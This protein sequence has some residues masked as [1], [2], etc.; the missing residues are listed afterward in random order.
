MGPWSNGQW[1]QKEGR[2]LGAIE[3]GSNTADYFRQNVE[4]PFFNRYLK[5][6]RAPGLPRALVFQTGANEWR[7]LDAWPPAASDL[8][9][10][11]LRADGRLTWEPPSATDPGFR[12]Y[13]SDPA[14]PVP[15]TSEI[16]QWYNPAFMLQDQRFASTRT[17]VLVYQTDL[18]QSDVTVAGPVTA[19]LSVSTSGTDSDWVVKVI[20][21][22]PDTLPD[23]AALACKTPLGGYQMLVRGDVMRGKFRNSL[24]VPEPFVPDRVA[25]VEFELQDLFHTFKQGHRIMVQVQSTWF[26]MIDLNPQKFTDIFRAQPGDFRKALQRVYSTPEAG[27]LLR[28]PVLK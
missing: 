19:S 4:L 14:K 10:L 11:H 6:Q 24:A 9:S 7:S 12:E 28:M 8:R 23:S 15:Y 22:F 20:D 3:F 16:A 25:K 1:N 13:T 5:D 21:V 26:P 27:S 18:L 17:D 2:S